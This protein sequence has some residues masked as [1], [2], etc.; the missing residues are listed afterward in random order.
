MSKLKTYQ[1]TWA[2]EI[3]M[4]SDVEASSP[5]EALH[6]AEDQAYGRHNEK[7]EITITEINQ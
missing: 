6:K 2:A 5:E 7:D 1:V 4:V 3:T